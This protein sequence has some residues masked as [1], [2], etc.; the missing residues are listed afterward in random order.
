MSTVNQI[1]IAPTE[2][3][4]LTAAGSAGRDTV[5]ALEASS[6]GQ[7]AAHCPDPSML[8]LVV[9]GE[10]GE[11]ARKTVESHLD[12]CPDCR[13]LVAA[14]ALFSAETQEPS[15]QKPSPSTE[16]SEALPTEGHRLGRYTVLGRLGSGAMGIVHEAYDEVLERRVALKFLSGQLAGSASARARVFDEAKAMA[17][18][19]HQNV[20][21]VYE[22]AAV[23]DRVFIAMELVQGPPLSRWLSDPPGGRDIWSVLGV[24]SAA[25]LGLAAA[26]AAGV[27]HRDFKPDN[28]LL[29]AGDQPKVVDF[30]L[31]GTLDL[32]RE[33]EHRAAKASMTM[34]GV[35]T[36]LFMAPEIFS[37]R[38]ADEKSDQFSFCV[39]L[40]LAL[41]G[42]QPFPGHSFQELSANVAAGRLRE[43]P[44]RGPVPARVRRAVLRGLLADSAERWP[45]MDALVHALKRARTARGKR[46][47]VVGA[48]GIAL[49][50]GALGAVLAQPGDPSC[51]DLDAELAGVWDGPT[52]KEAAQN[53]GSSP[54]PYAERTLEITLDRLDSYAERWTDARADLC[55]AAGAEDASAAGSDL[56]GRR[57]ACLGDARRDLLAASSFLRSAA[58]QEDPEAL[59]RMADGLADLARCSTPKALMEDIG[60]PPEALRHTVG[61]V[62]DELAAARTARLARALGPAEQALARAENLAQGVEYRPLR[63]EVSLERAWGHYEAQEFERSAEQFKVAF[64]DAMTLGRVRVAARAAHGMAFVLQH[65][66]DRLQAAEVYAELS[67]DL[68]QREGISNQRVWSALLLADLALSHGE[69]DVAQSGIDA[70]F[71]LYETADN[72]QDRA[73]ATALHAVAGEILG[74][75]G[76]LE[77]AEAAFRK[78]YEINL[79]ALGPDHPSTARSH[80]SLAKPVGAQGR[81]EEALEILQDSH[82]ALEAVYP[83]THHDVLN[84]RQ[85]LAATHLGLGRADEAE[86]GFREVLAVLPLSESHFETLRVRR[87]LATALTGQGRF[88]EAATEARVVLEQMLGSRTDDHPAV[89]RSKEVLAV[90]LAGT[91]APE[92][93]VPLFVEVLDVRRERM[94]ANSPE[95]LR[96]EAP[97]AFLQRETTGL[98]RAEASLRAIRS[99]LGG[100]V[101]PSHPDNARASELLSD[102]LVEQGRDAA[103]ATELRF[104]LSSAGDTSSFI[105][106]IR[107]RLVR[108]LIRTNAPGQA[109]TLLNESWEGMPK[110]SRASASFLKAK[111]LREAGEHSTSHQLANDALSYYEQYPRSFETEARDIRRWLQTPPLSP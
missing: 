26:H 85:N 66:L 25:G 9:A 7:A 27:V 94:P 15:V 109:L 68:A 30:G 62:R 29:T 59:V 20:A 2:G 3:D 19:S 70:A 39:A 103:E 44:T 100:Q 104:A 110:E 63:G 80:A 35:G 108:N 90:A 74:N 5:P 65:G 57:F 24:F 77:Q 40:Y 102:V 107:L 43:T 76:Q 28:V 99:Q 33:D 83:A 69:L 42:E 16:V 18:V 105:A 58:G 75:R 78:A 86:A 31:A 60:R 46:R 10:I 11:N 87:N 106:G 51:S 37:G 34:S 89:V 50:G 95:R 96:V 101:G 48:G 67:G 81:F 98:D 23:E 53:I 13:E 12:G 84:I 54:L 72:L 1:L 56:L 91:D 111:L 21:Q 17:R 61:L 64:R 6:P 79:E 93:A 55:V 4:R 71:A 38:T 47:L 8:D 49:L 41:Y 45:S 36:P 14:L 97:L 73:L 88:D 22:A 52:R 82:R 92:H 32:A